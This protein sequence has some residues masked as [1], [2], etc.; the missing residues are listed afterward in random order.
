ME[1]A[2]K[3]EN[4]LEQSYE[5]ALRLL[6]L[7]GVSDFVELDERISKIDFL[8]W[9]VEKKGF[10]LHGSN[11]QNIKMLEPR[12]ANCASKEFGNMNAVYAVEDP[13]LPTFY[14]I[15][16]RRKFIGTAHSGYRSSTTHEGVTT[17]TYEFA[18]SKGLIESEPWS[19][20]AVYIVARDTFRQGHNDE[21]EPI[22]EWASTAAVTPIGKIEILTKDFPYLKDIKALEE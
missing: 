8:K 12:L 16:D 4:I 13:V 2:P 19:N 7:K 17:K 18:V 21:G 3:S 10:L 20:G 11:N 5:N 1:R 22:D 6:Y 14:A 15:K 9:L